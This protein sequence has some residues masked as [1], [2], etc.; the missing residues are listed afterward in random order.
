MPARI[1]PAEAVTVPGPLAG[2]GEPAAG[3]EM[4]AVGV[5]A[6]A[7]ELVELTLEELPQPETASAATDAASTWAHANRLTPTP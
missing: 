3:T 4:V 7:K 5:G 6:A 1:A 2:A